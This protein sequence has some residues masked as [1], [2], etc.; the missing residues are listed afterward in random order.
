MS[1]AVKIPAWWMRQRPFSEW[2][3]EM[4]VAGLP[5]AAGRLYLPPPTLGIF[6]L[7][8]L[9]S[10][11]FFRDPRS[12]NI[13]DAARAVALLRWGREAVRAVSAL[14]E[15]RPD[16]LDTLARDILRA[17]GA[18]LVEHYDNIARWICE[19]PFYGF[20]MIPKGKDRAEEAF[21]FGGPPQAAVLAS[22][23]DFGYGPDEALWDV[24]L[25]RL[26]H[27]SAAQAVKNEV[28][29]V[30]RP[31]DHADI[32]LQLKLARERAERGEPQPWDCGLSRDEWDRMQAEKEQQ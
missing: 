20:E 13:A 6:P 21:L 26:G 4:Q 32:R 30:A 19:V 11:A 2:M 23:R 12:A 25:C 5:L 24:P 15:D 29:G 14:I 7:L 9:S 27:L 1:K 18:A 3:E 28:K 10:N 8:E 22:A 17:D 31:D 16:E